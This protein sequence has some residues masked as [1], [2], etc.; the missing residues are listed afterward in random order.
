VFKL[1]FVWAD[2]ELTLRLAGPFPS[3]LAF[4]VSG[5]EFTFLL[6]LLDDKE[7]SEEVDTVW[8]DSTDLRLVSESSDFID[9]L[10]ESMAGFAVDE[11]EDE[12]GEW[13]D[14]KLV[15]G[16]ADE[17]RDEEENMDEEDEDESARLVWSMLV[18]VLVS[19]LIWVW[20][21]FRIVSS[22]LVGDVLLSVGLLRLPGSLL[23]GS[24]TSIFG[25]NKLESLLLTL[26]WF[27]SILNKSFM[28][29]SFMWPVMGPSDGFLGYVWSF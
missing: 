4:V 13:D 21:F 18:L 10:D 15:D 24:L 3:R 27:W 12:E 7:E 5:G 25:T 8:A 22:L 14:E 29:L 17:K 16:D 23:G 11:L 28:M 1:A 2:E 26:F 6:P 20:Q 9:E 19:M